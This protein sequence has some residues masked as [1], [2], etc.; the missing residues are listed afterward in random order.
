[1]TLTDEQ[2]N[3][4]REI[5]QRITDYLSGGGLFNPEMAIHD[6]VRDLLIECRAALS[7]PVLR[8]EI[9][10]AAYERAAIEAEKC[11]RHIGYNVLADHV[12][13]AIRALK[14]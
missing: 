10:N 7:D 1:M 8:G 6:A 2:M 13:K 11:A 5:P 3:R 9:E 4:V 14:K 12:A